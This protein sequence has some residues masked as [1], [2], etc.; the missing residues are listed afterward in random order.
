MKRFI[1]VS[2]IMCLLI[3]SIFTGCSDKDVASSNT[4]IQTSTSSENSILNDDNFPTENSTETQN[5]T[6]YRYEPVKF[7]ISDSAIFKSGSSTGVF[8]YKNK[9]GL[10]G[11]DGKVILEP[12]YKELSHASEGYLLAR[13]EDGSILIMNELG[14]EQSRVNYTKKLYWSDSSFINGYSFL[15]T[16]RA[17]ND[18]PRSVIIDTKG[19]VLFETNLSSITITNNNVAIGF[20]RVADFYNAPV[21]GIDMKGNELWRIEVSDFPQ[22]SFSPTVTDNL[23]VYKSKENNLWGAIDVNGNQVLECKYEELSYAGDGLIGVL[24][25]GK[26]GYM[27]YSGNMVIEPQFTSVNEFIKRKALVKKDG[28]YCVI[29][30]QGNVLFELANNSARHY[31]NGLFYNQSDSDM[32]LLDENGNT[33]FEIPLS[34]NYMDRATCG[35]SYSGGDIFYTWNENNGAKTYQYYKLIK[36]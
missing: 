33:I 32:K 19:N 26:W 7:E 25:Y 30:T 16:E 28:N 5:I 2:T 1:K 29:D 24:K 18:G 4:D 36:N 15:G 9:H 10:V 21:V 8:V 17:D 22:G 34:F 20:D 12:I 31:D 27:D 3:T 35:L 14:I 6:G 11:S 13:Q 23:F